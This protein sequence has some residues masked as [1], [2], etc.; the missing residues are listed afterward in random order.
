MTLAALPTSALP[1]SDGRPRFGRF[2]GPAGRMDWTALAPP[3]ARSAWWRHFHHKRWQYVALSTDHLFCGVAIVDLGWTNTA[4]AYAF[5]RAERRE[6]GGYSQDGLPGLTAQV[7]DGPDD[8]SRF[9]FLRNRIDYQPRGGGFVLQLRCGD[10]EID[11]EAGPASAPPLVAVGPIEGGSVHAT[12]KAPGMPLRG[13][14]RAGGRTYSLD[15]GIASGDYSNGLLARETRW[16][17]ASAHGA[18]IGFNL[19]A[20]YFGNNENVLWLDG[21]LIPLG[22]ARFDYDAADPLAPWHVQTD[23]GLLDLRFQ[24][25][26]IRREDKDLLVAATRYVQPIGCFSGWVKSAPDAPA[27]EVRRLCGVTEDHFSRW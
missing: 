1:D 3:H 27:R 23:D 7:A 12:Q 20:G 5:D 13:T 19:Q 6:V 4:F 21:R 2:K 15:G 8:P 24:P 26:G 16:L 10:F 25:E 18:D 22:A 11:A 17:W 9:R 14:V